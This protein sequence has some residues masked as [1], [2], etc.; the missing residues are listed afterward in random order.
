MSAR[1]IW[2]GVIRFAD[3]SVPVKFYSAV[4]DRRVH[5]RLLHGED[6]VPVEQRMVDPKTGD[7][8]PR[9]EVRRGLEVE[10]GVFVAFTGEELDS[11][12]PEKS[13]DIRV[14]SFVPAGS[15]DPRWYDRP[16][17]LKPDGA[18]DDYFALAETLQSSGREGIATW[19][20]RNNRYRGALGTRN[21]YL[22]M[23]TLRSSEQVVDAT[24]LEAPEGREAESQ[25][26]ELAENLVATLEAPFEHE[27][28]ENEYREKVR[29]LVRAKARGETVEAGEEPEPERERER[30]SLVEALEESVQD[31]ETAA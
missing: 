3:V 25:E 20:M 7:A 19:V 18:G 11:L 4:E 5:F 31:A 6:H 23:M 26:M 10:D 2:K 9:D 17:Y 8:V 21:G 24:R 13:R 28:F 1:A 27:R 29:E 15:I 22:A 30:E 16:Y 14:A 12:E